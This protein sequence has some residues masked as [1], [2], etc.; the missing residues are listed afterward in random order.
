M[1]SFVDYTKKLTGAADCFSCGKK[2]PMVYG[3]TNNMAKLLA[4]RNRCLNLTNM[5]RRST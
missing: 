4:M 5:T 1:T 3:S 2:I